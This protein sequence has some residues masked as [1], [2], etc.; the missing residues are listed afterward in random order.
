MDTKLPLPAEKLRMLGIRPSPQRLAVYSFLLQNPCHPTADAIYQAVKKEQP[1]LSRT[2]IYNT[3]K[4]LIQGKAVS[5][6]IIEDG[7]LRYDANR[8]FHAHFKCSRCG[9]IYDVE[10]D[11]GFSKPA[12]FEKNF[13]IDEIHIC[14]RGICHCDSFE[15]GGDSLDISEK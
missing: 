7:E 8:K 6:V 14:Y 10:P 4:L 1:A 12:V 2:T 3:L 5:T 9:R 11:S 13:R 15:K